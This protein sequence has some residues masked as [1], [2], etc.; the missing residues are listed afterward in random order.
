MPRSLGVVFQQTGPIRLKVD[1]RGGAGLPVSVLLCMRWSLPEAL[2]P[3]CF[4]SRARAKMDG[5]LLRSLFLR[6]F[7][8]QAEL[9]DREDL[10]FLHIFQDGSRHLGIGRGRAAAVV[11]TLAATAVCPTQCRGH[12]L[13]SS[14][15]CIQVLSFQ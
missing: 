6:F 11:R 8:P 7:S 9:E 14:F 10:H 15:P 1:Q 4:P 13:R 12:H 3:S 2:F 5:G